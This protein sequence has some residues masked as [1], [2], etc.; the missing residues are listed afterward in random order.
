MLKIS[1]KKS[2][3]VF[4]VSLFLVLL[5]GIIDYLTGWEFG[6]FIFYFLPIVYCAWYSNRG[7]SIIIALLSAVT[8]FLADY[9]VGH[10]YSSPFFEYWN[11]FIRLVSFLLVSFSVNEI[12]RLLDEERKI[13]ADLR[14]AIS[15]V[16]ML[17]GLLPICASCKKIRNDKG[18]WEQ[19][20][21]YIHN[22]SE[23]DFTH[24]LCEECAKKLYPG[25]YKNS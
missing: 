22:H 25:I 5:L 3:T 11:T 16:K 8:W 17:G 14:E 23:A 7:I 6:F 12:K 21:T 20:E 4:I 2:P 1:L 10:H 18:Y 9:F 19:I 13:S 15:Q 24:G